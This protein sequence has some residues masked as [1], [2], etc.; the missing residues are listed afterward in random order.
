MSVHRS[1]FTLAV[2]SLL[3]ISLFVLGIPIAGFAGTPHSC[4]GGSH[5]PSSI[6]I[7]GVGVPQYDFALA[8][9]CYPDTSQAIIWK[10]FVYDTTTTPPTLICT[11]PQ[12]NVPSPSGT[13]SFSCG[14][15]LPASVNVTINYKTSTYGSWMVHSIDYATNP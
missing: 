1:F 7:N 4:P 8:K 12:S 15:P 5:L 3:F 6:G 13:Q 11:L 2:V 14:P 9:N 10:A